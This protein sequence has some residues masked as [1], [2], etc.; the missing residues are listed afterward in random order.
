M[1]FNL[2]LWALFIKLAW[3]PVYFYSLETL[4]KTLLYPSKKIRIQKEKIYTQGS[5]KK[6]KT[7]TIKRIHSHTHECPPV[8]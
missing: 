4:I 2:L 7:T 3:A 5:K 8:T 6:K 1:T